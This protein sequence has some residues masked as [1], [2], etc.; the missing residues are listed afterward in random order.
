MRSS[1]MY[2]SSPPVENSPSSLHLQHFFCRIL[3][4]LLS[5][6][7]DPCGR[8]WLLQGRHPVMASPRLDPPPTTPF[9]FSSL[10]D[11]KG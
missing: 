10:N 5:M 3:K 4:H 6:V 1:S 7:S 9:P 8:Q 11:K 2:S